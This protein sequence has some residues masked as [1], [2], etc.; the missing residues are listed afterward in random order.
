ME[1]EAIPPWEGIIRTEFTRL[2]Q[3]MK[4]A[5]SKKRI[6]Y[7]AGKGLVAIILLVILFQYIELQNL[8]ASLQQADRMLILVAFL[9][10]VPNLL[11]Q[12]ARWQ[13]LINSENTRISYSESMK[14]LL[15]GLVFGL[16]TPG[17]VGEIGRIFLLQ[18]PSKI[19]L[20]GLHVLDKLYSAGL[21]AATGPVM[22][23]LLP[24]VHNHLNS[25][26]KT[27]VFL[28]LML[29]PLIYFWLLL[30]QRPL[31]SLLIAIQLN[32]QKQPRFLELLRVYDNWDRRK[33]VMPCC[34]HWDNS[35][36][37]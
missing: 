11:I 19:R 7:L 30:D 9:L 33:S 5:T 31:K 17:R 10:S 20:A 23:F 24:D 18:I 29:I 16:I 34:S 3:M 1:R 36:L 2:I 26:L 25:Q 27:G 32:F 12:A 15:G 35:P 13:L 8:R 37:F 6:L 21:I 4:L 22:I 14:S 28:L